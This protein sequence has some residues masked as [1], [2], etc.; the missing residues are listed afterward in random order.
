MDELF[1]NKCHL[2]FSGGGGKCCGEVELF[3]PE[4]HGA[5][6]VS[7]SNAWIN[8]F[9]KWENN[10]LFK[11]VSQELSDEGCYSAAIHLN[12]FIERLRE[13]SNTP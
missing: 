5:S 3:V 12:V 4:K 11:K 8:V 10:P 2:V 6:L 7:S 9:R 13:G 1:C